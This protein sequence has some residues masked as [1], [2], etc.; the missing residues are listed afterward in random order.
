MVTFGIP[1]LGENVREDKGEGVASFHGSC[2]LRGESRIHGRFRR[3]DMFT[4]A[5]VEEKS[6]L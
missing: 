6:D 4:G 1:V 3:L 5:N 2:F